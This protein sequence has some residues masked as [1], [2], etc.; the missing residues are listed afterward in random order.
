MVDIDELEQDYIDEHGL[1]EIVA[2]S[3]M[4]DIQTIRANPDSFK[5]LIE[6]IFRD[7]FPPME[8]YQAF[9]KYRAE[10]HERFDDEPENLFDYL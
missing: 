8:E 4:F 1:P 7:D 2:Y 5:D 6:I 3:Y 9:K 10:L